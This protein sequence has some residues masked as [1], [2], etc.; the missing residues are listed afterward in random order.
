IP[1]AQEKWRAISRATISARFVGGLEA[2][3]D[4][5][6]WKAPRFNTSVLFADINHDGLDDVC[7]RGAGEIACFVSNWNGTGLTAWSRYAGGLTAFSDANGWG[8]P[9]YSIVV[10]ADVNG[11]GRADICGRG[12]GE[13][14]CYL[15]NADGSG[16]SPSARYA[17]GLTAFSDDNGR[18]NSTYRSTIRFADIN[19]DGK[20]DVCC[21]GAGELVCYLAS[22]DG[23]G[24]P[25]SARYAGGLTAFSDANGWNDD[26]YGA[27]L[28]FADIDGDGKADV[29]GRG[30]GEFACFRA[31]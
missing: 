12:S 22:A 23:T 2:F 25:P 5:N 31:N 11:D 29:C 21:R 9:K 15:A 24:F 13:L 8:D 28:Q 16:F 7:G 6:G 27:T 17:G 10:L 18:K 19:G 14:A 26:K 20:A 30:A 4:A 1:L 3:S